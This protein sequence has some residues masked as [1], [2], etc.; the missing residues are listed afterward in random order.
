M[1][2]S[3]RDASACDR[4]KSFWSVFPFILCELL[5]IP[6]GLCQEVPGY[7]GQIHPAMACAYLQFISYNV[8]GDLEKFIR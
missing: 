6:Q 5:N 4:T 7:D 8:S 3:M 1:L 2:F